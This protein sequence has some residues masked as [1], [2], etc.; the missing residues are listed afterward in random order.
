MTNEH[1]DNEHLDSDV[2]AAFAE[3]G[4]PQADR[5]TAEAHLA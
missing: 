3:R 1:L 4:L 5:L 2:I